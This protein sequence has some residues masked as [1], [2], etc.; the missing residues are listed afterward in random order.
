M[1]EEPLG[2][3]MVEGLALAEDRQLLADLGA[4][5]LPEIEVQEVAIGR[6]DQALDRLRGANEIV[7][8]QLKRRSQAIGQPRPRRRHDDEGGQRGEQRRRYQPTH[9]N[10]TDGWWVP[11]TARKRWQISPSVTDASTAST[12]RKTMFSRPR[13]ARSRASSARAAAAASP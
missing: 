12:R 5:A 13:A 10:V 11:N 8:H 1:A 6:G 7:G 4:A 9:Q 3:R 2:D